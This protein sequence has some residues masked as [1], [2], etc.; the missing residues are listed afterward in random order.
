[1]TVRPSVS[2]QLILAV[3][4]FGSTALGLSAVHHP[5]QPGAPPP[6]ENPVPATQESIES[7]HTIYAERCLD[8]HGDTGDGNGPLAGLVRGEPANLIDNVWDTGDEDGDLLRVIRDG[9]RTGMRGYDRT[10]SAQE[11]WDTVNFVRTLK[12]S[13][14]DGR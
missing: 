2:T 6:L 10:L 8:C 7:G 12:A 14:N 3:L 11:M 4:L 5:A 1:M 13:S 9:T